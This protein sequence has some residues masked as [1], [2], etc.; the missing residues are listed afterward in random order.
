L[1]CFGL[2]SGLI[3]AWLH[4]DDAFDLVDAAARAL[5]LFAD[6]VSREGTA[7]GG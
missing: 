6:S 3:N 1:A 5:R 4:G 2:I 7:R